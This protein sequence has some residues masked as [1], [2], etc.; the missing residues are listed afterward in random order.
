MGTTDEPDR[1]DMASPEDAEGLQQEAQSSV[2]SGSETT[3]LED[4]LE[5]DPELRRQ[6]VEAAASSRDF[7]TRIVR[8]LV[9][10]LG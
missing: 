9:A 3:P 2:S 5:D 7:R 8:R 10:D 6:I 4:A 1:K